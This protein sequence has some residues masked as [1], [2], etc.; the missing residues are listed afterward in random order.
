M[1][2]WCEVSHSSIDVDVNVLVDA[3]FIEFISIYIYLI[4]KNI[5]KLL[6]SLFVGLPSSLITVT[7]LSTRHWVVVVVEVDVELLFVRITSLDM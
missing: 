7:V 6:S 5:P 4:K 3:I 2:W 1:R